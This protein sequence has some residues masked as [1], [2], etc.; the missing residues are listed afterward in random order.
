MRG[1]S[2]LRPDEP[3]CIV[4]GGLAEPLLFPRGARE[5]DCRWRMIMDP[6]DGTRGL[7]YQKRSGWILTGVAPNR[8]VATRLSDVV[9]AVQTE[10]PLLK[11]HLSDQ[12]WALRGAGMQSRRRNRL[13]SAT[14][15]LTLRPSASRTTAHGF[16][17]VVRFFPGAREVLAAIA[18][19]IVQA[20]VKPEPR[21]ASAFS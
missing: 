1:L 13:S 8:G 20:V 5:R 2:R 18:D 9:L 21:P 12:L 10:I 16:A 19:E 15:S 3:V 11:Q 6:L 4:A 14:E 17:T 7:M